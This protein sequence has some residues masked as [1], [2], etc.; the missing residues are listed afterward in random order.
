MRRMQ[1][2]ATEQGLWYSIVHEKPVT[3][4]FVARVRAGVYD[5]FGA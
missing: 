3:D 5:T 2:C 4:D 1:S